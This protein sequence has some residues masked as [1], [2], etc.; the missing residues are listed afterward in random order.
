MNEALSTRLITI[1]HRLLHNPEDEL[2]TE[3]ARFILMVEKDAR[4]QG[5]RRTPQLIMPRARGSEQYVK[6]TL[7]GGQVGHVPARLVKEALEREEKAP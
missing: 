7:A 6:I 4:Q 2:D 5:S 1:A 3:A